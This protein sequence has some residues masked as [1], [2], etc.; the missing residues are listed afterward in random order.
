M[1]AIY[2]GDVFHS[3]VGS[4]NHSF[5][6]PVYFY[7]FDVDQLSTL[8]QSVRPF[9]HNSWNVV[10]VYDRDYLDRSSLPLRS[11]V[12]NWLEKAGS[13]FKPKRIELVSSARFFGYVFNPVSFFYCY[14]QTDSLS[15]ILAEVSNTFGE[16]HLY[17]A[18]DLKPSEKGE[19]APTFKKLFHVSPFYARDGEYRFRFTRPDQN[20]FMRIDLYRDNQ[21]ALR[22]QMNGKALEF[23]GREIL[24]TLA[25]YPLTA[26]LTM[27]RILWQAAKLYF[28]KRLPVYTKPNPQSDWTHRVKPA[29]FIQRLCQKAVLNFLRGLNSDGL[30][31]RMPEGEE[32]AFGSSAC[33]DPAILN[34]H[35]YEFFKRAALAGDIGLGESFTLA[36]WTSPN[37]VRVLQFFIR[38]WENKTD[39]ELPWARVGRKLNRWRHLSRANTLTNSPKNIMDHYDLSNDFFALFLDPSMTYSSGIYSSPLTTLEEAQHAKLDRMI[40]LAQIGPNDHVLEIGCGWGGFAIRA[41]KTTG[42]RV[43][44]ITLSPSQLAEAQRRVK[45]AGLE[46]QIELKLIDYRKMSGQFDKIVSIEMLEAVGHEHFDSYFSSID[47]LLKKDGLV[48]LQGITIPDHRYASYLQGVDWIQ[49]H[50]FPG[51]E[52]ASVS[53]LST[54]MARSSKLSIEKLDSFPLDY[55]QTL[56]DWR[57]TFHERIGEVRKLGFGEDFIRT[58]DYYFC[59]CEAGFNERVIS[60][61]QLQLSRPH[62]NN[63]KRE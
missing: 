26:A 16:R 54:S 47:R 33:A 59:Y 37:P 62:N 58:W 13:S 28:G 19:F 53:G 34:I 55:A 27:P 7:R 60:V 40:S 30:I 29:N 48:A 2:E 31:L 46:K 49:K 11:K 3:R 22:G 42:C 35:S 25:R 43:T 5:K 51:G 32:L 6:Y 38:N 18:S 10:S 17:V 23:S 15:A 36:E 8:S 52:I 21:L 44:G 12:E 41:A 56:R 4:V 1:N 57:K 14:D 20:Y 63:L 9:S 45:A 24:R 39:Q 50:I 61:V